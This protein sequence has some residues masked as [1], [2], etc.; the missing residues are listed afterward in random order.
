M[1]SVEYKGSCLHPLLLLALNKA[2]I[3]TYADDSTLYVRIYKEWKSFEFGA[4]I[5]K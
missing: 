3:S 1:K 5:I 4:A 2:K